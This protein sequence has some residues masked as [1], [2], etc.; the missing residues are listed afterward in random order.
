MLRPSLEIFSTILSFIH[1]FIS[2]AADCGLTF[3]FTIEISVYDM[4]SKISLPL[5]VCYIITSQI[6]AHKTADFAI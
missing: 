1:I 4:R 5:N 2:F 3:A 6:I